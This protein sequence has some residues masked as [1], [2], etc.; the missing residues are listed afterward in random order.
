M[1]EKKDGSRQAAAWPPVSKY[2]N[3][4]VSDRISAGF[5]SAGFGFGSWFSPTVFRVR[6]PE[7]PR[8]WGGFEK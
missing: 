1:V 2:G 3:G 6:I 4:A 8:V 5:G 7:I